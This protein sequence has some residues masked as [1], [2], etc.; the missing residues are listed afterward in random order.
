MGGDAGHALAGEER[1][2]DVAG[3]LV[4]VFANGIEGHVGPVV[5]G[6]LGQ[7]VAAGTSRHTA[8]GIG[9]GDLVGGGGL[10]GEEG[11]GTL[12]VADLLEAAA[13]GVVGAGGVV[14][15]L[16]VIVVLG[17]VPVGHR[18][19]V[20][21]LDQVEVP[22]PGLL[23]VPARE[24]GAVLV[25][26]F[27]LV[28]AEDRD[29]PHRVGAFG[30]R[31]L[32]LV[33][34]E[35]VGGALAGDHGPVLAVVVAVVGAGAVGDGG[36]VVVLQPPLAGGVVLDQ[37]GGLAVQDE[38]GVVVLPAQ[39]VLLVL[40]VVVT[41]AVL[42]LDVGGGEVEALTDRGALV[43]G[44][45][46]SAVHAAGVVGDRQVRLGAGRGG[47]GAQRVGPGEGSRG[48]AG[49]P[50][51]GGCQ[52]GGLVVAGAG[53]GACRQGEH[54]RPPSGRAGLGGGREGERGGEFLVLAEVGGLD[55]GAGA[56][57][58]LGRGLQCA[59][60]QLQQLQAAGPVAAVGG[61]E[62]L[63]V[64]AQSGLAS[65]F[66]AGD[67]EHHA[68]D[69][70]LLGLAPVQ[71]LDVDLAGGCGLLLALGLAGRCE[72]ERQGAWGSACPPRRRQGQRCLPARGPGDGAA[73]VGA[74]TTGRGRVGRGR[75]RHCCRVLLV[76]LRG[77][78]GDLGGARR[79]QLGPAQGV[80][81][82]GERDRAQQARQQGESCQ[83]RDPWS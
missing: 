9:E 44:G 68:F 28:V 42:A 8:L 18:V 32:Q 29:R 41:G 75:F 24:G 81:V 26:G 64:Q 6:V 63:V 73:L 71:D 55:G 74:G 45:G 1:G 40:A 22:A 43:V 66:G 7:R 5:A 70:E 79:V 80:G 19:G 39:V 58:G 78:R 21:V 10:G 11:V 36:G 17:H 54:H 33:Q 27:V 62:R 59:V 56:A 46:G 13:T 16:V 38:G 76:H 83:H 72:G 14:A 3:A 57:V 30:A 52:R 35:G 69:A 31:A 67:G 34:A 61:G 53:L 4:A 50:G 51:G 48:A 77:E 20:G 23:L 2:T 60:G 12:A 15:E 49:L 82:R 65:P 25:A 37:F 47:R